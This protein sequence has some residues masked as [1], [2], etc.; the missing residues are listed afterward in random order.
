MSISPPQASRPLPERVRVFVVGAGFAGLGTAIKLDENGLS[1]FLVNY[2]FFILI[3][4][5][6]G[7][8]FVYRSLET[9]AGQL[10]CSCHLGM[11]SCQILRDAPAWATW[12]STSTW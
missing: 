6:I 3:A 7:A 4:L 9:P 2:G 5:V 1:D 10:F 11:T 8:V 12:T